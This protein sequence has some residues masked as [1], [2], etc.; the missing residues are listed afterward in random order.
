MIPGIN[1]IRSQ[2]R[3]DG[4]FKG[5]GVAVPS[6]Q[7]PTKWFSHCFSRTMHVSNAKQYLGTK[8]KIQDLRSLNKSL[9]MLQ[10]PK[11]PIPKTPMQT[12]LVTT[13]LA[14]NI[15][16]F[17]ENG[18]DDL[19]LVQVVCFSFAEFSL[20]LKRVFCLTVFGPGRCRVDGY[21]S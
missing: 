20:L 16:I 18:L 4:C 9:W 2:H 6:L 8:T 11:D 12:F 21:T 13:S 17:I 1:N 10:E 3:S 19:T 7:A 14:R 15:P 5:K